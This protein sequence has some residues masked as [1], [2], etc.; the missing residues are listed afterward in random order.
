LE[1]SGSLRLGKRRRARNLGRNDGSFLD[2]RVLDYRR[3]VKVVMLR[4]GVEACERM[5]PYFYR[6]G[7]RRAAKTSKREPHRVT[8]EREHS[9]AIA[10]LARF[11]GKTLR[12]A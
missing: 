3:G 5:S 2:F 6:L 9:N 10:V 1:L 12:G 8:A 4:K 7:P 11:V